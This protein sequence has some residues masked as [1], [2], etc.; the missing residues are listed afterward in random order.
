MSAAS[1][2]ISPAQMQSHWHSD[3]GPVMLYSTTKSPNP[4]IKQIKSD[5]DDLEL[6]AK[7][8]K[9]SDARAAFCLRCQ[10]YIK[11]GI[12]CHRIT[13]CVKGNATTKNSGNPHNTNTSLTIA[14]QLILNSAPPP[15]NT[16]EPQ[17]NECSTPS[18]SHRPY[19]TAITSSSP[20]HL[21]PYS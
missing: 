20:S 15:P 19:P 12:H 6:L 17:S 10:T 8:K 21:L 11:F 7:Q 9:K 18:N 3:R 5:E 1:V 16:L 2:S 4:S 13:K 14:S